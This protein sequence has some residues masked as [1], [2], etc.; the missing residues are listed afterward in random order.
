MVVHVKLLHISVGLLTSSK[1]R[2]WTL[3]YG[4]AEDFDL[5][6]Y[7]SRSSTQR[8]HQKPQPLTARAVLAIARLASVNRRVV[9]ETLMGD[10]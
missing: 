6:C 3:C 9:S 2:M 5:F 8:N 10:G 4:D 7:F 1:V